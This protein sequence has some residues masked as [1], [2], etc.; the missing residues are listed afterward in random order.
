MPS[1]EKFR[2]TL[3][4]FKVSDDVI[5]KMYSGFETVVSKTPKKQKAVFFSQALSVMNENLPEEQVR[6]ILEANACCKSGARE[7]RSKEFAR[8]N[9]DLSI[10]ERLNLISQR[11]YMNMGRAELDEQGFLILHGVSYQPGERF[12]CACPTVSRIKREQDIP[13]EY[14]YC[15]GGH[16][17]YHYEIMLGV[18]LE[19]VEILS[20]PHDTQGTEPCVFKYRIIK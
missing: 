15:C 17:K 16:F 1:P 11:P 20:S 8:I 2:Q 14:C 5:E 13:R 19:I 3:H 7:R 18:K 4:D 10:E 6:A 12:E 9:K